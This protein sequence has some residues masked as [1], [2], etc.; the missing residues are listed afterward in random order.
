MRRFYRN[1]TLVGIL[2][3]RFETGHTAVTDARDPLQVLTMKDAKGTDLAAHRHVPRRRVTERLQECLIVRRGRVR[4]DLYGAHRKAFARVTLKAGDVFVL[5][6]GGYGIR[7]LED[8][9][10]IEVK[11]GPYLPD[12][13]L[14]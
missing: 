1:R 11:N 14:L 3:R 2:V 10:L 8:A 13:A 7:V 6:R 5:R 9:E 4:V 12:K